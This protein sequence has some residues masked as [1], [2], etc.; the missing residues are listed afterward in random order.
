MPSVSACTSEMSSAAVI[1]SRIRAQLGRQW[2]VGDRL[3]PVKE[4]ARQMGMGQSNTQVAVRELARDGLLVS[5]RRQGTF[6]ASVPSH[7]GDE[8]FVNTLSGRDVVVYCPSPV[9]GFIQRMI[10]AFTAAIE[11]TGALLR[12]VTTSVHGLFEIDPQADAAAL[13]NPSL[14]EPIRCK[15][16]QL[17]TI[18]STTR[19]IPV[20]G[21]G[22]Y[23]VVG[24]DDHQGGLLA[25]QM[26]LESG[27]RRPCFVGRQMKS[28]PS[29]FD[30]VSSA[31]L[32]GFEDGWGHALPSDCLIRA[33]KY[34]PESGAKVFPQILD[35]E[36]R[37]DGVFA[38]TDDIAFGLLIAADS[39]GLRPG[40]DLHIVGFDGQDQAVDADGVNLSTVKIPCELMGRRAARLLMER[41]NE[42]GRPV[43]RLALECVA[44]HGRTTRASGKSTTR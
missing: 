15:P 9:R 6:V 41:F 30:V 25:G 28:D 33:A 4:L 27:C 1:K 43:E 24:I 13:F 3:P 10:D 40:E 31:R 11:P 36:D 32:H 35:S 12:L 26:L 18:V 20:V 5:R 29:R 2:Q 19:F 38:A 22:A 17:L 34:S 37:P 42:P 7:R 21:H 44:R 23:D 14:S 39:H 8:L 16:H